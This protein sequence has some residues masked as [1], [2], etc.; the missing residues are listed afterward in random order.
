MSNEIL[1]PPW[2][3]ID[4]RIAYLGEVVIAQWYDPRIERVNDVRN[5]RKNASIDITIAI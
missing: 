2:I 1:F 5:G 3:A 4:Y